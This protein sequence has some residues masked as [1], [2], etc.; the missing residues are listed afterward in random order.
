MGLRGDEYILWKSYI[1]EMLALP[2][3]SEKSICLFFHFPIFAK[4]NNSIET[5]LTT[6]RNYIKNIPIS[7]Y[8][9]EID[10]MDK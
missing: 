8:F 5:I 4:N 9:G 3:G 10:W 1:D 6:N 2:E 7:F